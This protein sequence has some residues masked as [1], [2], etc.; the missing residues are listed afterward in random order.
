MTISDQFNQVLRD[1]S[2]TFMR[3]SMHDFVRSAKN[4]VY[5]WPNS[6]RFSVCIMLAFVV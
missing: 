5:P 3:R 6:T 4:L 2:E 1:W